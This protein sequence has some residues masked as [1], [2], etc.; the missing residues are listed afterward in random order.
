MTLHHSCP[1][2]VL[3]KPQT[4]LIF[5]LPIFLADFH[6]IC[7]ASTVKL[8]SECFQGY[9]KNMKRNMWKKLKTLYRIYLKTFLAKISFFPFPCSKLW[10]QE[11]LKEWVHRLSRNMSQ[12]NPTP[13]ICTKIRVLNIWGTPIYL[14]LKCTNRKVHH[15]LTFKLP[16]FL[17][18][19]LI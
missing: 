10:R 15:F 9:H 6:C 1:W 12:N 8:Y 17:D 18:D 19:F 11:L 14:P 7:E 3:I 2:K 4:F 13:F 5:K 16:T